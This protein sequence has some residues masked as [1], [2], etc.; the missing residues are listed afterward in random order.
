MKRF[1]DKFRENESAIILDNQ[2]TPLHN[3]KSKGGEKMKKLVLI[4]GVILALSSVVSAEVLLTA[5]PMGA[6]KMGWLAAGRYDSNIGGNATVIGAG[7][8]L[9]YGVTDKLDIYGKLGYGS[10]GNLPAGLTANAIMLGL[11]AKYQLVAENGKDMPVS[12]AAVLG[13][14]PSTVTASFGGLSA[15]AVQGDIGFGAIV[16]KV[17]VPWVPYGA[18]VFHSLTVNPGATTGSNLEIVAGTQMLLSKTS[19]VIG[20]VSLNSIS[21]GGASTSNTQISLGYTAKI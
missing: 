5:N 13:Y 20:E 9:G 6:G 19:A 18:L 16:S 15:Q 12:V 7:G 4:F 17:I 11:A 2:H 14:Q 3:Q 8:F 10:Y 21:S 1:C